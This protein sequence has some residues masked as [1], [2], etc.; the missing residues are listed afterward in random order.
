MG[1][2]D[3]SR[4]D[5]MVKLVDLR[6]GSYAAAG[7]GEKYERAVQSFRAEAAFYEQ[8]APVLEQA[9]VNAGR[10]LSV[11]WSA[12]GWLVLVLPDLR[13]MPGQ[14]VDRATGRSEEQHLALDAVHARAALRWLA[15]LHA[16]FWQW[17]PE[18]PRVGQEA[19]LWPQVLLS[20]CEANSGARNMAGV[21]RMH[22]AMLSSASVRQQRET[23]I[24]RSPCLYAT[25]AV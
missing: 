11:H 19:G 7:K 24:S 23:G 2:A 14:A 10:A 18:P 16:A 6:R 5:V 20:R 22:V 12:N 1:L 21:V 8:L 15:A 9:G 3:G 13:G 4:H 25:A 17:S